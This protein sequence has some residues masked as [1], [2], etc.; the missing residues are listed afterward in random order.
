MSL[1][2]AVVPEGNILEVSE[3]QCQLLFFP[4]PFISIDELSAIK[5]YE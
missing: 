1:G 4:S 3:N 5:D 2:C